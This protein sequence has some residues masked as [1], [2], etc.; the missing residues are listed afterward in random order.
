MYLTLQVMYIDN[1]AR[2]NYRKYDRDD[3]GCG[4]DG[5]PV[6]SAILGGRR[7]GEV[8]GHEEEM[9]KVGKG[10]RMMTSKTSSTRSL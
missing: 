2:K 7:I 5:T 4:S 6:A 3:V 10:Y 1:P 8:H 9:N